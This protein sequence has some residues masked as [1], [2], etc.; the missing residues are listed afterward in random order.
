MATESIE[1]ITIEDEC[2]E[3][4]V[5][6]M[7]RDTGNW[8]TGQDKIKQRT[9]K[10]SVTNTIYRMGY[11]RCQV[12]SVAAAAYTLI[13]LIGKYYTHCPQKQKWTII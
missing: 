5:T 1:M 11:G 9:V 10:Y 12:S 8:R 6:K 13:I 4:W 7:R 2:E 3:G